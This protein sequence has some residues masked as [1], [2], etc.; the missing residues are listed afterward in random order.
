MNYL[1]SHD[2]HARIGA[3]GWV[4]VLASL[5][6]GENFL[7]KKPGPCPACGGRD[8]FTFDNR[9]GRGDYFCRKCEAGD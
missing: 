2:I 5:G 8:R 4:N 9:T 1:T 3:N 7:R 6:V